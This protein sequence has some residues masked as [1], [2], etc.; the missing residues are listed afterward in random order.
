MAK[1]DNFKQ[2]IEARGSFSNEKEAMEYIQL[3]YIMRNHAN[4]LSKRLDVINDESIQQE[5][6][7]L[8]TK[9]KEQ[10]SNVQTALN[11]FSDG[12]WNYAINT[13]YVRRTPDA[14]LYVHRLYDLQGQTLRGEKARKQFALLTAFQ[15]AT[16]MYD[17]ND[18][19][20]LY[21]IIAKKE[22]LCAKQIIKLCN[23]EIL[24]VLKTSNSDEALKRFEPFA[25]NVCR[26]ISS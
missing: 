8:L 1:F 5:I 16:S 17:G 21:G 19:K 25:K 4:F 7:M 23:S 12:I 14:K 18:L 15:I 9:H 11:K 6:S 26:L 2:Y 20:E 3:H 22:P 13:S 24:D 10:C